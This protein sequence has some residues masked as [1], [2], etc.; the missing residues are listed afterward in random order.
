MSKT[1]KWGQPNSGKRSVKG[2]VTTKGK[3]GTNKGGL[4]RQGDLWEK[5]TGRRSQK[6]TK[7]EVTTSEG[8]HSPRGWFFAKRPKG[9]GGP[10][11]GRSG[12]PRS[13]KGRS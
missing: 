11:E 4:N 9:R 8:G 1:D 6:K 3:V 12:Q 5:T 7:E 2:I 10:N 13:I